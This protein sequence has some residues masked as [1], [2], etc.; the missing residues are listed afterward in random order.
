MPVWEEH[1]ERVREIFFVFFVFVRLW[2][3]TQEACCF[4]DAEIRLR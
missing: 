1:E 3:S 4:S 2:T